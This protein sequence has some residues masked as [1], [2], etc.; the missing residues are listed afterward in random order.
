MF[1]ARVRVDVNYTH[2]TTKVSA[3]KRIPT[4]RSTC[5]VTLD[6]SRSGVLEVLFDHLGGF[7]D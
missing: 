4:G 1:F 3:V 6:D 7:P 2:S 5:W